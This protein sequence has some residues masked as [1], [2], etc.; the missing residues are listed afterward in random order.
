MCGKA[1]G[2]FP[3]EKRFIF[4]MIVPIISKVNFLLMATMFIDKA[5]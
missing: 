3:A 2:G 4:A 5:F 1:N